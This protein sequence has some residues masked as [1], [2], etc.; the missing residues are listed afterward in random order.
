[1]KK[2]LFT[3]CAAALLF[4]CTSKKENEKEPAGKENTEVKTENKTDNTPAP[5]MDSAGMAAMMKAWEDFKTPGDM[6]KWMAKWNGT[7]EGEVTQWM[8]PAAP[9]VKAKATNVSSMALNGLYQMSKFS[10]TMNGQPMEGM[11]TMGYDN[12]KK[13]FVST[14]VDN[15]GSGIVYMTGAW[16]PATKTMNLKGKQTDPSTGKDSDIREEFK[17]VD[18]NTYTLAMFGTGHDGKEMKF[19]EG[20]FK[21]KK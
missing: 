12:V 10:S 1:M 11:S 5:P 19:M 18:D 8:D 13:T 16:D 20:T 15:L 14:W 9:P 4:A 17:E 7:W 21:K 3:C 2:L 6:H